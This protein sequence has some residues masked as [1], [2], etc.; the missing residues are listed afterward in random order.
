L[1]DVRH[2]PTYTAVTIFIG[3]TDIFECP[4]C[5]ASVSVTMGELGPAFATPDD[6]SICPEITERYLQHSAAGRLVS[7]LA[8][9]APLRHEVALHH[10]S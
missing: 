2:V 6:R 8:L 9:C 1:D 5:H 3:N 10:P 4:R 7:D